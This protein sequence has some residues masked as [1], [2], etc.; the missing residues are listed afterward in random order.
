M[1]KKEARVFDQLVKCESHLEGI[2]ANRTLVAVVRI[3]LELVELL[4][5]GAKCISATRTS[6][7]LGA[8]RTK[9][10]LFLCQDL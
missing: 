8:N 1:H 9:V 2:S 3:A 7:V 4:F 5:F 10:R 6:K